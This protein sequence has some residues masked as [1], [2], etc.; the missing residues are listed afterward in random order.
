MKE[1]IKSLFSRLCSWACG[2]AQ[3]EERHFQVAIPALQELER[4]TDVAKTELVEQKR[5]TA[6]ESKRR[7]RVLDEL[8][9]ELKLLR[10]KG[11][12]R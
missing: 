7:Q 11:R 2:W 6:R 3:R 4:Q 10:L 8:A 5:G 9:L 1:I 12:V